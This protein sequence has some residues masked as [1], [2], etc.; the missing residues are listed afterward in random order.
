MYLKNR[1]IPYIPLFSNLYFC[2]PV[3]QVLLNS[4]YFALHDF[5]RSKDRQTYFL[6]ITEDTFLF[7]N[8]LQ[9]KISLP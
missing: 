7:R 2:Y 9:T 5:K 3:L 8:L 4:R 6:F 1:M